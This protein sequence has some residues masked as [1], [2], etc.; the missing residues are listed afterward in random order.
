MN[1]QVFEL[2]EQ[3][4]LNWTVNKEQLFSAQ[5]HETDSYGIFQ[6]QTN[7]WLALIIV[8]ILTL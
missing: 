5:G 3:T 7:R 4:D 1:N 8:I 2:L 6:N